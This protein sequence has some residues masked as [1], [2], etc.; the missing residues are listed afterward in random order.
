MNLIMLDYIPQWLF[1]NMINEH[2]TI[3]NVKRFLST[4]F[5]RMQWLSDID[6]QDALQLARETNTFTIRQLP[7]RLTALNAKDE[8]LL[9]A[10]AINECGQRTADLFYYRYQ[11]HWQVPEISEHFHVSRAT[12]NR[13]FHKSYL[14]FADEYV[15]RGRSL[16]E[17]TQSKT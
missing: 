14:Q 1:I 13:W 5:Q 4:D 12:I 11:Q 3:N 17:T 16:I 7:F 9:V 6:Y 8:L 2:E 10:S 15:K